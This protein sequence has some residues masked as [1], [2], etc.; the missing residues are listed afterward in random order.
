MSAWTICVQLIY[1]KIKIRKPIQFSEQLQTCIICAKLWRG[2]GAENPG[3][4]LSPNCN[5]FAA[6]SGSLVATEKSCRR[7]SSALFQF[8]VAAEKWRAVGNLYIY[9]AIALCNLQ[10]AEAFVAWE[11][12]QYNFAALCHI[13]FANDTVDSRQWMRVTPSGCWFPFKGHVYS[14]YIP[15]EEFPYTRIWYAESCWYYMKLIKPYRRSSDCLL[16]NVI[17]DDSKSNVFQ[18][19]HMHICIS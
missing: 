8:P 13:N 10:P 18:T 7:F 17:R 1:L 6:N 14:S 9:T 11:L 16:K 3:L 15:V 12:Q 5:S 4:I 2:T 19:V